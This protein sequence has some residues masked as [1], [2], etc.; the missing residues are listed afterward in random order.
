LSGLFDLEPIRLCYLNAACRMDEQEARRLS[1]MAH[2]KATPP[3]TVL[4]VGAAEL[5]ELVRQTRD[6]AT[7]L[8][9][10]GVPPQAVI[11]TPGDDHFSIV[12]RLFDPSGPLWRQLRGLLGV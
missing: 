12:D 7:A 10:A 4:A 2:I 1:P 11:E 5:P 9:G 6:Y 3:P 8:A